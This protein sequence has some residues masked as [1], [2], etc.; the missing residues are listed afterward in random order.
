M[1]LIEHLY[2]LRNRLAVCMAAIA[3]T[4]VFGFIWFGVPLF[5]GPSLG[6]LLKGP[7]C[8]LPASARAS[9][10]QDG[11]CV[12]FSTA[13]FDQ[14]NLR[15]TV[16][17]TVG[18]VLACPIWLQQLWAFITP[19]LYARERRY[20]MTFVPIAATLFV[21][22]AV[23]AYFVVTQALAFL[24][25]VSSG[26]QA[27]ALGGREYF[28]FILTL[29]LIFGVSFELPLLVVML[30]LAGVVS[31]D[32]LRKARRGLV[33]GLFVFAAIATPGQDPYSMIALALALTVLF[34]LAIQ[35]TRLNDRRKAR[36]RAAS[37]I[38][39]DP[40]QPSAIDT[41]P[42]AIDARPSAL[43]AFDT[44]DTTGPNAAAQRT[45]DAT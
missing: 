8:S 6:D 29:L 4:T 19:G 45:E 1:S 27:T 18:V 20:A 32:A 5:G 13:P 25:T 3:I 33:F 43:P 12:L 35:L 30:N 44:A 2:E 42:S 24:L 14:F 15:L 40:D 7:Y 17:T 41:S 39:S 28:G 37:G 34:E 31:Y 9:V 10:T 21:S 36:K 22:G 38:D 11:S 23:L 16:A 26:V